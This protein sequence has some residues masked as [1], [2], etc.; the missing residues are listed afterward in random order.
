MT[1]Q[2]KEIMII[3]AEEC[4]EVIQMVSKC[5][6]FGLDST[7]STDVMRNSSRLAIEIG[8]LLCMVDLMVERGLIDN[9]IVYEASRA[10]RE[11]LK[12][13]S[14]IFEDV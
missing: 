1:E 3:A 2:E 4:G 13:W 8:D 9:D 5:L 10:K 12:I 7:L 6:R 14:N 11:K